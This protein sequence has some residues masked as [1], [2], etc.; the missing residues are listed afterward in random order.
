MVGLHPF[1]LSASTGN[2]LIL[3]HPVSDPFVES[4]RD[5][6]GAVS[7]LLPHLPEREVTDAF[8]SG[9]SMGLSVDDIVANLLST[10]P[11]SSAAD[12]NT[13][14]VV[15]IDEGSVLH[16][17]YGDGVVTEGLRSDGFL[18]VHL[19]WGT[20]FCHA[21]NFPANYRFEPSSLEGSSFSGSDDDDF[22][23]DARLAREVRSPS[24]LH[25][26][27]FPKSMVS[28]WVVAITAGTQR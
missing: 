7:R 17:P 9:L 22:G 16:T 5:H 8:R 26:S 24:C 18:S 20:A 4:M 19:G 21:S 11:L 2:P 15:R 12:A 10:G 1:D 23:D 25:V 13:D 27:Q 6:I 14:G 3:S 28:D